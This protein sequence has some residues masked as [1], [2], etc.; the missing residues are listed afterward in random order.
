MKGFSAGMLITAGYTLLGFVTSILL[1]RMLGPQNYGIYVFTL[2]CVALLT[3][4][5]QFGMPLL[6]TRELAVSLASG[7]WSTMRG[8]QLWSLRWMGVLCLAMM[9]LAY[10]ML[11]I[12]RAELGETKYQALVWGLGLIPLLSFSALH[13]G[14]LRGLGH[15]TWSMVSERLLRP[16]FLCVL[17]LLSGFFSVWGSNPAQVVLLY[18]VSAAASL[19]VCTML[20]S[21]RFPAEAREA[22][23]SYKAREWLRG[24]L[25]LGLA[26]FVTV[27][28]AQLSVF[29]LG[30]LAADSD[31]GMYRI[32]ALMAGLVAMV[33]TVMNSV[34]APRYAA[35]HAEKRVDE[36][37]TLV[38]RT[39]VLTS[40]V[41]IPGALVLILGGDWLLR[42][43][44][45]EAFSVAY[46]PL[47]I[48][49]VAQLA[50]TILGPVGLLLNMAGFERDVF[51]VLLI[52]LVVSLVLHILLV[53]TL[54]AT[55][56][57][58]AT[59]LM[60]LLWNG[61]LYRRVRQRLGI[62]CL[63]LPG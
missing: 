1:T 35:L 49:T 41:A 19:T 8:A 44:Y 17:V 14:M 10:G 54:G 11:S 24:L 52:A 43:V 22:L 38:H 59:A 20:L 37:R 42:S 7:A 26:S 6:M 13:N 23:P 60:L 58:L 61:V 31:V 63:P 34:T 5:T 48:L 4:P 50:N 39:V 9:A 33:L 36:L 45:G 27:L 29:V 3:V 40:L 12:Y 51:R 18:L 32:A 21:R 2:S 16:A 30:I 15:V 25:P 28:N 55:G 46:V 62:S 53:P 56:A 57:A 47:V